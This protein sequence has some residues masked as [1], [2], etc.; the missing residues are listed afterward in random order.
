MS[1]NLINGQKWPSI[2]FCLIP[3]KKYIFY[4]CYPSSKK[5]YINVTHHQKLFILYG[6]YEYAFSGFLFFFSFIHMWIAIL[7]FCVCTFVYPHSNSQYSIIL[8]YF[9]FF[10]PS[11]CCAFLNVFSG[12]YR[13]TLQFEKFTL[14]IHL[15]TVSSTAT[16]LIHK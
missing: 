1:R 14:H 8:I 13:G 10:F 16:Q 5:N 9:Y 15:N 3:L 4:P 11:S 2:W 7:V 12:R 6:C